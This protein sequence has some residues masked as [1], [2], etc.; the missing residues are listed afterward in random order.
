MAAD[1]HR[2]YRLDVAD[3]QANADAFGRPGSGRGE[4]VG[5]YPQAHVVALVECGTH[6]VIDAALGGW[7]DAEV[8]LAE[9]LDRSLTPGMLVLGDRDFASTRLVRAWTA[10]GADVCLR[11]K[12]NRRLPVDRMLPD[13]SWPT[14]T[15]R[16]GWGRW[17]SG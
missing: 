8:R 11:V 15:R 1:G 14:T 16:T 17:W 3:S 2:R 10:T 13:G 5:G 12:A 9:G 7:H 6:A 4:G